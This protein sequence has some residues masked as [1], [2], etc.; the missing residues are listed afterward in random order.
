MLRCK[1]CDA[2]IDFSLDDEL[3]AECLF[4]VASYLRADNLEDSS[5]V[6][7]IDNLIRIDPEE[8]DEEA[9]DSA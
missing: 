2:P 8:W 1:A 4:E 5:L 7:A 9:D 6:K 3:C